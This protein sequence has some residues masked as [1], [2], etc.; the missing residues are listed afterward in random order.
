MLAIPCEDK[1][2]NQG[3]EIMSKKLIVL[4]IAIK[5]PDGGLFNSAYEMVAQ[6]IKEAKES[7][8]SRCERKGI[9]RDRVIFCGQEVK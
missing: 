8:L 7:F 6:S 1:F 2:V 4:S 5:M 9:T 3:E